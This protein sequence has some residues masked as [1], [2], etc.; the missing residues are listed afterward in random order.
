MD[1]GVQALFGHIRIFVKICIEVETGMRFD[2]ALGPLVQPSREWI[3][4]T[5][6]QLSREPRR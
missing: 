6:P 2:S 3:G 5:F 4:L 1:E